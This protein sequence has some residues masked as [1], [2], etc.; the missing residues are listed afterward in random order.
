MA[1][2]FGV[3]G[4]ARPVR[5]SVSVG[6]VPQGNVV[7]FASGPARSSFPSVLPVG[8]SLSLKQNPSD[9]T[10]SA[11]I[12]SGDD[13][14]QLLAAAR[15]LS[16]LKG[17]ARTAMGEGSAL[18]GDTLQVKDF[19]LP[20]ERKPDDAPRWMPTDRLVSLANYG[21]Q[22]GM[23]SDG[24]NPVPVYFRVAPDLYYGENQ[25]LQLHLNSRYNAA[26]LADGSALRVFINDTVINEAPLLGGNG[27]AARRREALLPVANMRP[28]ANTLLFHFDFPP[29]RVGA[30]ETNSGL[31]GAIL[32]DS[33]LDVRGFDHWATLPNLELF[34]NAGFPFT[35]FADLAGIVVVLPMQPTL[36]EVSLFLHLMGH[37][38]AQ[39]GYPA[40][41]V[42]VATPNDSIQ[43]DRDYLGLGTVANQ[44]AFAA[45]EGEP[46]RRLRCRGFTRRSRQYFLR[47]YAR[48][49]AQ[50][51]GPHVAAAPARRE[52]IDALRSRG[53]NAV[54][55]S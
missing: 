9:A 42:T 5:F 4:S 12:V 23:Q 31:Q 19:S 51:A 46:A 25:N 30:A 24:T 27:T 20:A 41:R 3:L 44:P 50:S 43:E 1:S 35:Q 10:G 18:Q 2:W 28:F 38:S 15:S 11:L 8:A 32:R 34:S 22:A 48:D 14:A 21:A 36:Q 26:P 45:L 37:F 29:R 53:G 7:V 55:L 49:G 13:A 16:L 47:P 52:R 17:S 33:S 6:Q 54:A 40:L 39:T